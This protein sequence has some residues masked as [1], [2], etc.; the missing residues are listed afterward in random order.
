M[1]FNQKQQLL[2]KL[3]PAQK[4]AVTYINGPLLILAGAGTGKTTVITKKIAWLIEQKLAQPEEILA[5]TFTEKAAQEMEQR[6]D[7]LLPYGIF[8][9]WISTFHSFA[10]RI[11]KNHALDIG[12]S[13]DYQLLDTTQTWLLLRQKLYQLDL[14]YYR[15]KSNPSKFIHA[16]IKLFSRLKDENIT[17]KQYLNYAENLIANQD[18]Q[19]SDKAAKLE[20]K[21]IK[22]TADCYF[23]YQQILLK[24][25]FIDFGDLIFYTNKLF[26][27]RKNILKKY[28]KQFKFILI[29]EF[30]DTNLAQYKLIKSLSS[31]NQNKNLTVVGDDDQSIFKFRGASISNILNFKRD[32]PKSKEVVLT[33][34]YRSGQKI[35]NLAYNFIQKNNPDR[36]EYQLN[37]PNKY[38]TNSKNIKPKKITKKLISQKPWPGTIV[39]LP[40]QNES[41]EVDQV[42][43]KIELLLK[44]PTVNYN[45][46]A[47]LVRANSAADPFVQALEN[48][49][50]PY[51]Y[52]ASSGLY[53]QP[54]I[55]NLL[56]YVR[57]LE[58][59]ADSISLRHV[60][61]LPNINI[62]PDDLLKL[63]YWRRKKTWT[64]HETVNNIRQLPDLSEQSIKKIEK[65]NKLLKKHR[66]LLKKRGAFEIFLQIIKD[67]NIREYL[68]VLEQKYPQKAL[69]EISFVNQ[70]LQKIKEYQKIYQDKSLTAF[71][72]YIKLETEA[73][74]SGNINQDLTQEGPEAIKI[75][76]VHSAKGLEFKYV[77][78]VNLVDQRFPANHRLEP[79]E[80]PTDLIKKQEILPQGDAHLQ[81]ERRLFYVA[82]TRAKKGVFLTGA[83]NYGGKREKKPSRFLLEANI[84]KNKEDFKPKKITKQ[85]IKQYTPLKNQDKKQNFPLPTKFSYSQIT[86]FQKCP[87]QYKFQFILKIPQDKGRHSF[88]FGRSMHN[89]LYELFIQ[90]KQLQNQKQINLFKENLIA[91]KSINIPLKKIYQIYQEN[92]QDEWYEDPKQKKKYYQDGKKILKEFHQKYNQKWPTVLHL[93]KDFTINIDTFI[94][95]GRIDR[96]DKIT[97]NKVEIVDY[98]TSEFKKHLS[99]Q[100]RLQLFIYQIALENTNLQVEKLHFYYLN[101]QKQ[102]AVSFLGKKQEIIETKQ[103]IKKII[104]QIQKSEFKPNPNKFNCQCCDFK[105]ICPHSAI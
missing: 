98:K 61:K 9:M 60:L 102:G 92:W 42:L 49:Q 27:Q 51:I 8:D 28:Q 7:E 37:H 59:L 77:F 53:N 72:E 31:N 25:N 14:D 95:K 19:M 94:I 56:S 97:D 90:I 23:Q 1:E 62:K 69:Q 15:P 74:S 48:K 36:L 100:D 21:R 41:T 35:L 84:L 22:E 26:V 105:D 75:L 2:K 16:L 63:N 78:I 86:A 101:E 96:I 11:L 104:Q 88:S 65:L 67:L 38:Y 79:I 87:L 99:K 32:Y 4:K 89:T 68:L 43:K 5:L 66:I 64:L 20:L 45:D 34:N 82:I 57:I 85:I 81:E 40:A 3:N 12:L 52:L 46:F 33:K 44:K 54:I 10:D 18:N 80:I 55:I 17:P 91:K 39:F 83:L 47:I 50:M 58:D 71:L 103:E 76:T 70:F 6:V 29:D 13:P 24:N 93:E 30:Q 73:G